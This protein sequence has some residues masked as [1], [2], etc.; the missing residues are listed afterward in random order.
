MSDL[1]D[2]A[3]RLLG[4]DVAETRHFAGGSLSSIAF[5]RLSDGREML[6][7]S[8]P[9]PETEA[10]MLRA[11]RA[12]GVRAPEVYAADE[13]VLAIERLPDDGG[14]SAAWGDLGAELRRLHETTGEFYGWE[15][16]YA[17]AR[18]PIRNAFSSDW[19]A[20]FAEHRLLAAA[21]GTGAAVERRVEALAARLGDILPH[22]P[23]PSLVHGD[24]WSGNVLTF[25]GKVSG[26]IDP[27]CYFGDGEVDV[28]MLGLFARPSGE[29][30]EAYG[31]LP[32]HRERRPVYA[33]WPAL[34]HLA[35]F[36]S[37]YR[38]MVEGYLAEAGF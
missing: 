13:S 36:G 2:R 14:L 29:F 20:F 31:K 7:K 6:V 33:L 17:F 34:V 32:G 23:K 27:A 28:A 37:G 4:G 3:A 19:P 11:I 26:L 1:A 18:L 35:L 10:R 21:R 24:L 15:D 16:D 38:S 25:S 5:V 30:Y 22:R 9:S 12:A 8:G